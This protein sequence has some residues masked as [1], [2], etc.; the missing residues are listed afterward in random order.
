MLLLLSGAVISAFLKFLGRREKLQ[1]P[2]FLE[3][4]KGN[5]TDSQGRFKRHL[6]QH[7]MGVR[8]I[9]LIQRVKVQDILFIKTKI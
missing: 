5:M 2:A 8:S 3:A 1:Y 9:H 4:V 6:V 7:T